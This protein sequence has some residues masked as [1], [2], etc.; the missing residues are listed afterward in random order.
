MKSTSHA[1]PVAARPGPPPAGDTPPPAKP[2][3]AW[4]VGLVLLLLVG[5]AGGTYWFNHRNDA[6]NLAGGGPGGRGGFRFGGRG[7]ATPVSTAVAEK[8]EL[9]VYL[10]ALGSVTALNTT[11]VKANATGELIA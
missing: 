1:D 8:G 5:A 9:K 7:G 6:A 11:T 4:V 2:F 10:S 3:K